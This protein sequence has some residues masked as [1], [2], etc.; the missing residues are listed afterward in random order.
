MLSLSTLFGSETIIGVDIGS[1]Q[2]KVVLAEVTSA[3][4]WRV[5]RVASCVTPPDVVKDGII[6]DRFLVAQALRALLNVSGLN[7]STGAIAAVAGPGV[8]VRHI[9]LPK[10]SEAVLRKSIKYE[11][12]KYIA[13][14][15]EDSCV[16]FEITGMS[17]GTDDKMDVMLVAA[18]KEMVVS[19]TETLEMAGLEP[20]S[21]DFEAFAIQR[22][23][24]DASPTRP[25]EGTTLALLSIGA[26]T[27]EMNVV[28]NGYFA[29]S[30]NI[31]IA[32][33][34][35]TNALKSELKCSWEEAEAAKKTVD[36]SSLL[37]PE[38]D[39]EA[40][41]LARCIQ[42]VLD[43]IMREVRR[44]T[45]YFRSQVNEGSLSLPSAVLADSDPTQGGTGVANVSKLIITGG[46]AL[47]HGLERYMTA[48]LGMTVEVWNAFDNPI[49]ETITLPPDAVDREH[50]IYSLG[51]G[52]AIKETF[53]IPSAAPAAKT[54]QKVA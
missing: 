14:S 39:L 35:F 31:T 16:E 15:I 21:M 38:A 3:G 19:R 11:A 2:I 4:Q 32:G 34:Q 18:P 45:N 10:M 13:T 54:L 12:A 5:T 24:V 37:N 43:E 49:F 41:K 52:L 28:A 25:G 6:V 23:L 26:T 1:R 50:P 53:D 44:S 8:I 47:L 30:R 36:M 29:L 33:D 20:V 51:L 27:T 42:P 9:Q 48:R 46:S 17:A 22:A 40:T 7:H